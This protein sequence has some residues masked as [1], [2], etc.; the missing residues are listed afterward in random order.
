MKKTLKTISIFAILILSASF[1]TAESFAITDL[2]F[3][4]TLAMLPI[5]GMIP[6]DI[7]SS[8]V[9]KLRESGVYTGE[10]DVAIEWNGGQASSF[11]D[12][13]KN[14]QEF[15]IRITNASASMKRVIIFPG[16]FD[17]SGFSTATVNI[18]GTDYTLITGIN[19]FNIT[20]IN[21]RGIACDAMIGDGT[22][23]TDVTCSSLSKGSIT[24]FINFVKNNPTRIPEIIL[25]SNNTDQY[26]RKFVIKRIHPAKDWGE[27]Y[28]TLDKYFQVSQYRDEKITINTQ[29]YNLQFDD[30]T[31][32]YLE[33]EGLKGGA[34]TTVTMTLK[35]GGTLN[36]A[37]MLLNK[38]YAATKGI[39]NTVFGGR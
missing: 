23:A 28:I 19:N 14:N 26:S 35:L 30:Q 36:K 37:S 39:L 33:V 20:G 1:I 38:A 16:Y 25:S 7:N 29:A 17:T 11:I 21:E 4:G 31:V 27:D 12:E 13:I 24:D 22:I 34:A 18:G 2:I 8:Q 9:Q 32:I 6:M 3:G 5:A 10:G 15:V